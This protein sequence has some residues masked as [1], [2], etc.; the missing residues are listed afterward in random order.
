MRLKLLQKSVKTTGA[1]GDLI[2]NKISN[3][4]IKVLKNSQ[5]N[6]SKTVTNE[7][8][9]KIPKERYIYLQKKHK[10]LLMIQD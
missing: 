6:N 3:K 1:T 7:H 10:K 4:I 2:G 5:H 9:K 8:H